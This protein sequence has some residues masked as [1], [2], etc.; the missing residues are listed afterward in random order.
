MSLKAI[1]I[2]PQEYAALATVLAESNLMAQGLGG[3]DR[4][5]YAFQ[6]TTGWRLGVST[7]EI[8]GRHAVLGAFLTMACHRAKGLGGQMLEELLEQLRAQ[9]VT[10]VWLFARDDTGFLGKH[11]FKPATPQMVPDALRDNGQFA[12]ACAHARLLVRPLS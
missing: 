2:D 9:G 10:H 7:I 5:Y 4:K 3:F 1:A 11:G 8:Y 12:D 6:D